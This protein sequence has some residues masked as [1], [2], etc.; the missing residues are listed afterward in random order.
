MNLKDI[1]DLKDQV[2][3]KGLNIFEFGFIEG[4]WYKD[5]SGQLGFDMQ[6]SE[7][8]LELKNNCAHI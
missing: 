8:G 3:L 4:E 5:F 6:L 1:E 2:G 7:S